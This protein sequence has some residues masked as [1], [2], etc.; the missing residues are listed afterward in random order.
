MIR[1]TVLAVLLSAAVL[2]CACSSD[3]GTM[4]PTPLDP[5]DTEFEGVSGY[6]VKESGGKK[7]GINCQVYDASSIPPTQYFQSNVSHTDPVHGAGFY[8]CW[9]DE[10]G[11]SPPDGTYL[12]V[13]GY[14]RNGGLWGW[15]DVFEWESPHVK[16]VTV[17][18]H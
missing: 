6:C 5:K 9:A 12:I 3:E 17:Y 16:W 10:E 7:N 1:I 14:N 4:S 11:I 2:L 18:E 13:K 8:A 15:S